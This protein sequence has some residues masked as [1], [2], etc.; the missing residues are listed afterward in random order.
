MKIAVIAHLK[1]PIAEPF[2]GGLEMHTNLLVRQ[3]RANGHAVTLFAAD[4]SDYRLNVEPICRRT[5][6]DG[7]GTAEAND[8][9]FFREHHAYLQLMTRLRGRDFDVVHNNA[10]HYLPVAMADTL[11]MPM[12]S[13]LHTPPFCWLESGI[14]SSRTENLSFV[15]VSRAVAQMWGHVVAVDR[16]IHNGIDLDSFRF[17]PDA[18]PDPYL[19]WY[20]RIVPEKGTHLAIRAA[21]AT[22]YRLRICGPISDQAYFDAEVAP[23][24]GDGVVYEG[25]LSHDRLAGLIG[26]ARAALVTPRW[27]EPYGLVVAEALACGVPIA[28]F[29]RGAI[30]E[31]ITGQTGVLARPDDPDAL[32]GAAMQAVTL[33]R[34]AC[35]MRAERFCDATVMTAAYEALYRDR[36]D[37]AAQSAQLADHGP[38]LQPEPANRAWA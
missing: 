16:V 26:G 2:A 7:V 35:R 38:A 28:A 13:V 29:D 23:L 3:L 5:A 21:R 14:R 15:G 18:D 31:I 4:G 1:Y 19:I 27:D 32:A 33:D 25:H 6:I 17:A 9:A 11:P 8:I 22:P 37:A 34:A 24:L 30:S 12:V 36:I 10:L 20:G